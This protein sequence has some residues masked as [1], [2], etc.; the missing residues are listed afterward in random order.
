MT[1]DIT[2]LTPEKLEEIRQRYRPTEVPKCHICG[3]EMTIQRMSASR[4]TYGCAGAIYDETGCHYAEG[5]SLADDHYAESRI[6]VVDVSDPD[7]LA[8]VD[9]LEKAQQSAKERDE[10][11]QD[12]MLTIGRLRVEREGLEAILA[13]AEKLV[14][15]KGRYHS[16]QNYR[17]LAALFGV[18]TPDLPPLEHENVHYAD[19]AEMD[20]AALR[21]RIAELESRTVKLPAELYT[22]GELIRTQDNRITDQPMFVVFQKREIIGS[23]EHSPSRICWVWDGEEV[24]ELRAK[25]LEA[26]YQDGRDTR[27]YDR[28]AMQEVDEF[29]TACFTEHGC[30]DYLRQNGHN[31]RLPYIYAYGSFRNN[32]YQLVRNWLAGIKVEDE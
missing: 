13:A 17:A 27:G 25:R 11:N 29:V 32:E 31:L 20:I 30:K 22:I 12:L 9:A 28:Y 24:S 19:A 5:R 7:V 15:C 16:E 4:I 14:R 3:S 6:T 21:Q 1:T 23:D 2:E 10:E 8:L 18:N 26:L